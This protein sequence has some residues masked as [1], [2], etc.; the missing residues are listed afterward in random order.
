ML[1]GVLLGV[2]LLSA[3]APEPREQRARYK[4]STY[5]RRN[6]PRARAREKRGRSCSATAS[7]LVIPGGQSC[8]FQW[9]PAVKSRSSFRF[10]FGSFFQLLFFSAGRAAAQ[11][12][13][14]PTFYLPPNEEEKAALAAMTIA[15]R[16]V[17]MDLDAADA[18]A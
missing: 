2:L 3:P 11:R 16:Q 8:Y 15:M 17:I 14:M 5:G 7:T 9:A 12:H 1:L 13:A 6:R 4:Y 18:V 10:H